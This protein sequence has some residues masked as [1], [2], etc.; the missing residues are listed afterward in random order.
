MNRKSQIT[1]F[2]IIC[3]LILLGTAFLLYFRTIIFPGT[4]IVSED[5]MPVKNY[6]DSCLSKVSEDAIVKLGIQG[7][8]IKIPDEMKLSES[9]IEFLPN[10]NILIPYWNSN[11][12][13]YVPSIET[14]Q[15]QISDYIQEN[16]Q[17]C[18]NLE[19]FQN[20]YEIEQSND[21]IITTVIAQED[22]DIT[23]AHQ[24]TVRSTSTDEQS[25]I[26]KFTVTVPARLRKV[27]DL[28]KQIMDA[29]NSK[30]YFEN[31]TIDWM[32]MNPKIPLNGIEFHCSDLK[33]RVEDVKK[34]LQQTIYY[35]LPKVSIKN[36]NHP[37]FIEKDSVYEDLKKYK[38]QDISEGN[39]PA[40]ETPEDAYDYSHYLLD[41]RASKTDLKAGFFYNPVWGIELTA[42]P[43]ENGIMNSLKQDASQE[44]LS[45]MCLNVY[46]FTYDAVYPI[47]VMVRDDK[48]FNSKGYI[49]RFAFPV[50]INHNAPDR[51]GFL[52]KDII[53]GGSDYVGAC[54]QLTGQEYDIRAI[55]LDDFGITGMSLKDVN[56]TY[57]CFKFRCQLGMTKA[58][59]GSY[60]LV[61]KLPSS[62]A[63][64][65]IIAE[66]EG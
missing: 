26:S 17:D 52:N 15:Q 64:G 31:M 40:I 30:T 39:Y 7:G 6:I 9:Y 29:E 24:M 65:F 25:K 47:E 35:N 11:G 56:I 33:W 5:I 54:D 3:I 58:D 1:V 37:G 14:M 21:T 51:K 61:T 22:V 41:V 63:H 10:S 43:S 55:G 16:I 49:F 53:I 44:F 66:K 50:M 36:T 32:S 60:R 2:I 46:H 4:E 12:I 27:Y 8:Y 57:D 20:D 23:M 45:F 48:S 13:S 19:I 62:C 34:E 38:L 28:A 59:E 42:R 18:I